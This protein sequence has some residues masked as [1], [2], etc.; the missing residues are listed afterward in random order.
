MSSLDPTGNHTTTQG[1]TAIQQKG[2]EP[3]A[4]LDFASLEKS[5]QVL[6]FQT[7]QEAIS[8]VPPQA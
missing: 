2:D 3:E 4:S 8:S 5:R 6:V 1:A 7:I